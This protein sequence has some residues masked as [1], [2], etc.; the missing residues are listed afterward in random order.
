MIITFVC[1]VLG[2]ENN[3]TTI[4]TFNQIRAMQA[5]G[6]TVRVVCPDEQYRNLENFYIC[7]AINF[8]IFNHYVA[9]NGVH[10]A[11]GDK[12]VLYEALRGADIAT[13]N[14]C[15]ALS[16]KAVKVCREL[17]VPFVASF[18]AQAENYTNH[19]GMINFGFA[20]WFIY[21]YMNRHLYRH[22][23]AIHYP[24]KFIR[25]L[26]RST[27]KNDVPAYVVSNGVRKNFHPIEVNKPEEL[28]D[29]IVIVFSARY[30]KEKDAT[31]L[32]KAV[33]KSK[34]FD[35]I[36]LILPGD[37]PK[38]K[39]FEK[40]TKKWPN[41]PIYGFHTRDELIQILNYADLYAHPSKID[42]EAISALEA[43]ACGL[44]P[45][46]CD[47]ERAAIRT[48]ALSENN[49][50]KSGDSQDLAN[51]IDYWIDHPEEKAQISK[52]YVEFAKKFD[53]DD[54]MDKME[55]MFIE[56]ATKYKEE[57]HGKEK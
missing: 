4:A 32:L 13:C 45:V 33:T 41:K 48:F 15:G 46:L 22:L 39:K 3:G 56:V 36:V 24:T 38:K 42:L 26:Y 47:S 51:K 44:V 10:P 19:V 43:M 40:F 28:K 23:Q 57:H 1:D 11:A 6:H 37:G 27:V 30:S 25:D 20:N 49:L 35:K 21:W 34:Y 2:D 54:A 9:S 16:K 8:Y 14:F 18:N 50:F 55:K 17:N 7:K 29:K 31:T 53:F 5:K 52:E 12:K